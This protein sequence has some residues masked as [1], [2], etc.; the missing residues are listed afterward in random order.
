MISVVIFGTAKAQQSSA[1]QKITI[2]NLKIYENND[3]LTIDWATDGTV[4]ASYWQLQSSTDGKNYKTFAL[5]FGPDP[6]QEGDRY[7]YKGRLIRADAAKML[8]RLSPVD[9]NGKEINNEIIPAT[10]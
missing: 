3:Q 5:V 7:Q 6:R 9:G 8:Y 4:A 2:T 1:N 10:K